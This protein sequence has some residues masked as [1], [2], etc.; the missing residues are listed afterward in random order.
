VQAKY[1]IG[2]KKWRFGPISLYFENGTR[3]GHRY[4]GRRIE[5]RTRSIEYFHFQ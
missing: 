3:Y 2:M 4:N 5:T 1:K